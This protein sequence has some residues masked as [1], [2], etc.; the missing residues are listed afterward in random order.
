[1]TPHLARYRSNQLH[2]TPKISS[3]FH[4]LGNIDVR[5]L[6][7]RAR[8]SAYISEVTVSNDG[9]F[10]VAGVEAPTITVRR[11]ET[12]TFDLNTPDHPF[13]LQTTGDG[14]QPANV[15]NVGFNGN[16]ETSGQHQWVVPEDAPD[17]IFYQCEFHP[18]M[19]GKIIVVD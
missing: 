16:G 4:S 12:Y 8:G 17:E 9:T 14:Y 5:E 6:D 7:I 11:N 3:L 1:M 15:Y 13:Y 19:F 18:V 10:M 2:S